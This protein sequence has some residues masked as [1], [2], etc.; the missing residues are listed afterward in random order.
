MAPYFKNDIEVLNYAL[1]LEH[2]ENEAYKVIGMRASSSWWNSAI[3]MLPRR[4]TKAP[5][6]E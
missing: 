1:T 4:T 5:S 3:P 6:S 2:L